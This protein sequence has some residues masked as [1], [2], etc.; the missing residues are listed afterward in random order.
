MVGGCVG[1]GQRRLRGEDPKDAF[2]SCC[3]RGCLRLEKRLR[4]QLWWLQRL[5]LERGASAA[6][7]KA[8]RERA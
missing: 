1:E 8:K 4:N 3:Q 7:C 6:Q 2:Q 5:S